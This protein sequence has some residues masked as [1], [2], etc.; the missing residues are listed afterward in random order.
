MYSFHGR[1]SVLNNWLSIP[2]TLKTTFLQTTDQFS[3]SLWLRVEPDSDASYIIS[4]ELGRNRYFSLFESG[5]TRMT[6]Y[7]FR[8]LLPGQTV[9]SDDGYNTQVALSF[10]YNQTQLPQGLRDNQWHFLSFTVAFPSV[11]LVID[12]V[13][14]QPTQGNYRNE[15]QSTVNQRRDGTSYTMPAPILT[16]TDMQINEI[17]ARIGGS[18]RNNNYGLFGEMRQFTMSSVVDNS[19]YA[20]LA[21]CNNIIGIDPTQSFPEIVTFY[22]PVTRSFSFTGPANATRYS[23]VLQSLVYFT[24]GFLLPQERG[25]RRV[26]T[27]RINDE[28]GLGSVA[29]INVVGRSNQDDPLLDAN[30]DLVA[31]INYLVVLR[32]DV[33]EDE[34]LDIL[35]PRSFITD[36]DIDSQIVSVTVNL[37]N[38]QDESLESIRL[39]DN[40]PTLVTVTGANGAPLAA[41]GSSQVVFITSIDPLITTANIF[42]TTLLS[43]RYANGAQEPQDI[44]RIIEFT[45]FD[46]LRTNNP[47]AQTII[48]VIITDDTP[49]VDLNGPGRGLNNVVDYVESSPP[50]LLASMASVSDPDSR[51]LTQA[52]ARIETIFDEGNETIAFDISS[53]STTMF[54]IPASCNGTEV[55]VTGLGFQ[56]D[57]QDILRTLQYVNLKQLRDLP[58]LRDRTVF[59]TISDGANFTEG[60]ILVNFIPLNPRVIIELAAPSQNYSTTFEEGTG[61][62]IRCSSL[63]RVVDSSIDT[64]E[65]IVVSIRNVLPE[66]VIE[67]EESISLTFTDGLDISIEINTALKRITFSQVASIAQYLEAVRRI[68]YFNGEDE[69]FLVNRFVDFLVIPGGGAPNDT[70]ECNI[71]ILGVNDNTPQCPAIDPVSVPE[72]ATDG[73]VVAQVTATDQDRGMDGDVTYTIL[74][75]VRRLLH[76]LL[77]FILDEI[78]QISPGGQVTLDGDFPLDRETAIGYVLTIEACDGG[79][80]PLCCQFNLTVIVTDVN[81]NPPMFNNS[82]YVLDI[83]ENVVADF[84]PEFG[85]SDADEGTNALLSRV[86]IDSFSSPT[87]C[88]NGFGVRLDGD[89]DII[90]STLAP[91]LDFEVARE[92][93]FRIVAYDAGDPSMS[94]QAMVTVIVIDQ[95]DFPPQFTQDSY[96]F[97]LEEGNAFPMDIGSVTATDVDSVILMFSLSGATGLFEIDPITGV[98]SIVF[99]SNRNNATEYNFLAVVT[100]PPGRTD[101]AAIRVNIVAINDE[102]PVLDLNE[103]DTTS[104][105]ARMPFIFMEEGGPVQILTE[106]LVT[107]PDDL[108]LTVT[109][110]TV[111]V[112]DSG[113]QNHEVL[114]VLNSPSTPAH[115]VTTS[116]PGFLVIQPA[117]VTSLEDIHTLLRSIVYDNTEDELSG[118]QSTLFPCIYGANA[119][120]LL[121]FVNDG[122]FSSIGS[123]AFVIFQLVNDPPLV[124]LDSMSPGQDFLTEFSEGS[125]GAAIANN[126]G[127]SISDED[128]G[129]LISLVCNLT[130]PLDLDDDSL[131]LTPTLPVGLTLMM[132]GSH[133][134]EIVGNS[135]VADF[136]TALG[137]VEYRSSSSNPDITNRMV[138]VYVID[139]EGLQSNIAV[140]TISFLPIND[141][142][143]LDLD[144]TSPEVDISVTF[145]EDG[146]PIALSRSPVVADVDNSNLQRLTV[147]LGIGS[148]PQEVLSLD[149][150]LISPPL[151]FSYTF[152]QLDVT[153]IASL[154][155]Y[156]AL[157]A[158]VR[159]QNTEGEIADTTPRVATFLITDEGGE[160][161]L[162][163]NAIIA[164]ETVDDNP[165]VFMPSDVYNFTV[166]E[167]AATMSLVGTVT[168]TDPDLPP[169]SNAPTF[170]IVA[171]TPGEGSGDFV[172]L[173]NATNPYQGLIYVNG[174]I[175]YDMRA[176]SY[177]L[178][179]LA[180]SASRNATAT[181]FINVIN[182]ADI[183]P[184]FPVS[185]CPPVF[186]VVENAAF[187]TPLTPPSCTAIDPDNLDALRYGIAGNVLNGNPLITIDPITGALTVVDNIDREAVG[188]EFVVSVIATDSTQSTSRNITVVIQGVN[189][190]DPQFQL[191]V[192]TL[193]I[194]ENTPLSG[195]ALVQLSAVDS[196][197]EPDILS[198]PNFVTRITYSISAAV[199]PYFAINT[200]S[201]EL[202]QLQVLDFEMFQ[203]FQFSVVAND[204]DP[205]PTSRQGIAQVIINV[206]NI[207][208]ERPQ[209]VNLTDRIIVSE[210]TEVLEQFATI[211]ASDRDINANLRFS[212]L[213][214]VPPQ[215]LLT[216]VSGVL[217][218][219]QPLDAEMAPR[220]FLI[221]LQVEDIATDVRYSNVS[222]VTADTTVIVRDENDEMPRFG[223]RQYFRT[224]TENSPAGML[225]LTV[226]A[227]DNDYGLDPDGNSNGNNRLTYS[228]SGLNA[229]PANTFAIDSLTGAITTL[230]P[231]NREDAAQYVFTV[232][233]QDNP[234]SGLMRVDTATVT[235]DIQ[236]VN[237]FPPRADP[238]IYFAYISESLGTGEDFPTFAHAAWNI[239]C[240][241]I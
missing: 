162:A 83:E 149:Q 168:I 126:A 97:M 30:G 212:I 2:D 183:P 122:R 186:S 56:P 8:D 129:N 213:P 62:P 158:S 118:C 128:S 155:T 198:T 31:G 90:L 87:G 184:V 164:I 153:G 166:L 18:I 156:Q 65:S 209:F 29:E 159:Y 178:V 241:Y 134:L 80:P 14:Y 17:V 53:L 132:D 23:L 79:S 140:A 88:I 28:R 10:F 105:D 85:I 13:E 165:P 103:T 89:G 66:G 86:E 200:S 226:S 175:D 237:E 150:S 143:T 101:T 214:P 133:V 230:Q 136:Q 123:S 102:S 45:V 193:N 20:C 161:S 121:Y 211:L 236:D 64:L 72:N 108:T 215:F 25:E 147:S 75:F 15:F 12:G 115:S 179:I 50:T 191:P 78:F 96:T 22:N 204:N 131:V 32:E 148:G 171:A 52:T 112:V 55:S 197:E 95:D 201:G 240:E 130:N 84:P 3:L 137:L 152:P 216:S 82:T 60:N 138:E 43:L 232:V 49:T 91:G 141:L 219:I 208:D 98:V 27:L 74:P 58:N 225:V 176:Q 59:V 146:P 16:K 180:R 203:E 210:S 238:D 170:T 229:P 124:D 51:Q 37:T 173:N 5:R 227:V 235:I 192:Y 48:E 205:S 160:V 70:A 144:S 11:R 61:S 69:P 114:S 224:V 190:H 109:R 231:L 54:C 76:V 220:E 218:A 42:I 127:Y 1:N 47:R 63:V 135:P 68:Q 67:N 223:S 154:A 81:D 157:I 239:S 125:L 189:E 106:P 163:V 206:N 172:I 188:L 77:D 9:A 100:D 174:P 73:Y 110:I 35:S 185:Q 116:T 99:T 182:L 117:N 145:T 196:D 151:A 233:V 26:I 221:T 38:A 44:D 94:G 222:T 119:R 4:F 187:S 93:S 167:N 40:P 33:R 21:S 139:D 113:N 194:E 104:L 195:M 46:G 71:T 19:L 234:V 207:N 111:E 142:P 181:V 57:Y 24:N 36:S 41:G 202:W 217:S 107:D 120:R 39:L 177:R 6:F 199:A 7:Y 169:T 92:C 228:F 34:E